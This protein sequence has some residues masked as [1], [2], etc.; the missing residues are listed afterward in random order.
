MQTF[1]INYLTTSTNQIV[2]VR[3]ILIKNSCLMGFHSI[4]IIFFFMSDDA[5]MS[6]IILLQ[7]LERMPLKR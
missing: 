3:Y 1:A 6:K 2:Y 5:I 4:Y 7:I